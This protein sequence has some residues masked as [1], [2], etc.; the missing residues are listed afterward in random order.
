MVSTGLHHRLEG[1]HLGQVPRQLHLPAHEGICRLQLS[2]E[3]LKEHLLGE[4]GSH[5]CLACGFSNPHADFIPD[6]QI[7]VELPFP[8]NVEDKD[9]VNLLGNLRAGDVSY[10]IKYLGDLGVLRRRGGEG[11]C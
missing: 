10:P 8:L 6:F 2:V 4:C 3:D 11:S 7:N 1:D 9:G 5:V